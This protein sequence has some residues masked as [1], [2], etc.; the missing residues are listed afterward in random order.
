MSDFLTQLSSTLSA[1]A[2]A[3]PERAAA[4]SRLHELIATQPGLTLLSL[5]QLGSNSPD[6]VQR[7]LTFVLFRRMAFKP[8]EQD[9]TELYKKDV[10]DV[11]AETERGAVQEGLLSCLERAE[12][13]KEHERAVI[14]DAVAEVENAGVLRQSECSRAALLHRC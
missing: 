6:E 9:V 10:W 14:C 13:R 7:V 1:L 5:I 12:R 3:G 11:L 8:L 2:S 4:E